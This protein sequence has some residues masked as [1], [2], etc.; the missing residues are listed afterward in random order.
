MRPPIQHTVRDLD[1]TPRPDAD[2]YVYL[3][4][5][6][7]AWPV[8]TAATG[9]SIITQPLTPDAWGRV[10]GYMVSPGQ[11]DIVEEY[12]G[13]SLRREWDA[14]GAVLD[15]W[16]APTFQNAWVNYGVGYD[17]AGYRPDSFNNVELKGLIK[18]GAIGSSAFTLPAGARPGATLAFSV[19][20]NA[21]V[22]R[23]DVYS[24][25]QVVPAVG[26]NAYV[27]LSNIRFPAE[28]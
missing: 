27:S 1:G 26:N 14:V 9:G 4:G 11:L 20:S 17:T 15:G 24:N 6:T 2:V 7:T 23:V 18:S 3:R 25:G 22:G 21:A 19:L 12:D 13:M 16:T 28:A 8:Y 5:T 10:S